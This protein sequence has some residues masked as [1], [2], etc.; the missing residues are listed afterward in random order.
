MVGLDNA[1]YLAKI[2]IEKG[3]SVR[4]T[5]RLASENKNKHHKNQHIKP[6]D[7]QLV[8]IMKDLEKRLG[9]QVKI[10]SGKKGSG[11]VVLKYDNPAQLSRI[12][13]ILEQR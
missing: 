11:S 7:T 2:I 10:S 5:E 4:E 6:L 3:L 8:N 9:L 13:D 12:L 1:F